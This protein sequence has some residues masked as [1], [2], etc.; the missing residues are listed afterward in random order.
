MRLCLC[1]RRM[2]LRLRRRRALIM[3]ASKTAALQ[4]GIYKFDISDQNQKSRLHLRVNP[5]LSGFLVINAAKMIWL[6]QS[7]L[8]MTYLYLNHVSRE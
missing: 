4:P 1:L 7:A 5:D 3:P 2:R 6:N 8:A